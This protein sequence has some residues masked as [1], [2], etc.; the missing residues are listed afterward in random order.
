M[1]QKEDSSGFFGGLR[2]LRQ[3][4]RLTLG[5]SI[6]SK[7]HMLSKSSA[8]TSNA[9]EFH[10]LRRMDA[11]L[12]SPTASLTVDELHNSLMVCWASIAQH[13]PEY[14]CSP[15]K[16]RENAGHRDHHRHHHHSDG[17]ELS[18]VNHPK[19]ADSSSGVVDALAPRVDVTTLQRQSD[20]LSE[21]LLALRKTV[22]GLRDQAARAE[23]PNV[24]RMQGGAL[25]EVELG[26]LAVLK[27]SAV[28]MP[29]ESEGAASR[30][31]PSNRLGV[32]V[33]EPTA[34]EP[35]AKGFD[36]VGEAILS[37]EL[38]GDATQGGYTRGNVT[39]SRS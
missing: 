38:V 10:F 28:D 7:H 1:I 9:K 24:Q 36:T 25:M 27:E 22:V 19:G 5:N 32:A 31:Y 11:M 20:K 30:G 8:R 26:R 4:L 3:E 39:L 13:A 14:F 21:E 33:T 15:V 18:V 16:D 2:H 17:L 6:K 29:T 35:A 12:K 23:A 37:Q 34:E